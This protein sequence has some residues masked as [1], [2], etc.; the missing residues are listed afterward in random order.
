M[1]SK[2]NQWRQFAGLIEDH[3]KDHVKPQYGDFPDTMVTGFTQEKIQG[4][5]EHYVGRIGKGVRGPE[6][7]A[8]DCLKIAHFAAY[9]YCL[10][11]HGDAQAD[12][13]EEIE[14]PF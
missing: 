6:E 10:I 8:R 1:F 3:I 11:K 4:K 5:L 14:L 9:L 2:I 7:A 13:S 12:L